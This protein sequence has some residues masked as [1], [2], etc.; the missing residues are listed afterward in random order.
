MTTELGRIMHDV[1]DNAGMR[2]PS[3]LYARARRARR[4]RLTALA[5]VTTLLIAGAIALPG[6][7]PSPPA[8]AEPGIDQLPTVLVSP[9][10]GTAALSDAPLPRALALY[11]TADQFLPDENSPLTV[12]GSDDRY[13]EYDRPEWTFA[14]GWTN[15]ILLSPDG[16]YVLMARW[17]SGDGTRS[18]LLDI[19]TGDVRTLDAGAPLTWSPDGALAALVHYDGDGTSDDPV[20]GQVTVVSMPTGRKLWQ[21]PLTPLPGVFREL[22]AALSPDGS[23]L[24]LQQRDEVTAYHGDGTVAWRARVAGQLAGRAAWAPDGR[25]LLLSDAQGGLLPLDAASG[26]TMPAM[27]GVEGVQRVGREMTPLVEVV[28]WRGDTALA[29]VGNQRL[30]ELSDPP[31]VLL[32]APDT[33]Y[34]LDVATARVGADPRV[35]GV[36]D[37]GPPPPFRLPGWAV[38]LAAVVVIALLSRRR[39]RHLVRDWLRGV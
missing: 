8:P 19:T 25:R 21:V 12:V 11:V 36:A 7:R 37:P 14:S 29:I 1:A 13:R 32:T 3:G 23:M 39:P 5:A 34:E 4:R 24:A 18:R 27:R 31:R 33:V 22:R 35:P 9:P 2:V 6:W 10:A 20:G 26:A 17:D 38:A 30:Y 15:T 28:G 16:R